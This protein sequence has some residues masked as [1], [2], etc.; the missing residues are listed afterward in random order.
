VYNYLTGKS[1]L[2]MGIPKCYHYGT[3]KGFN[4]MV[5]D[6]LGPSLE[7]LFKYCGQRFKLKTVL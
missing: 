1:V 7:D 6:A 4:I 2:N 3:E 5:M